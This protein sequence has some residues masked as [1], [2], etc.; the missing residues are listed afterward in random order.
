MN[1]FKKIINK[2]LKKKYSPL[3]IIPTNNLSVGKM[4]YHNGNFN[5]RGDQ[6]GVIGNYCAF[7]KN[8]SVITSNHDYNFA[9]IQGTFYSFYFNINHPGVT[10]VPPNKERT[11]GDVFIGN[12][13]WIADN[14]AILSGVKIGDGAC[15]GNNSIV[16]KDVEPFSIVGG[17]P[18]KEIK[19]RFNDEK[20]NFLKEL[21]WWDWDEE[22]I[23]RNKLFFISNINKIDI[24]DLK[25]MIK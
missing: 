12:D 21:K 8:V 9:S 5:F 1:L 17:I 16:T 18:A 15:I 7:G 6:K 2:V 10:Q 3:K 4:S 22:K 25:K 23:V 11:K 14:V 19:K 20:I 13:V 24:M